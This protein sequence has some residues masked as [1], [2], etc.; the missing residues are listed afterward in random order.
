MTDAGPTGVQVPLVIDIAGS[1]APITESYSKKDS[2]I[3]PGG[4]GLG[5]DDD[6]TARVDYEIEQ[7]NK[8]Y[9]E[10]YRGTEL[11]QLRRDAM[12]EYD[13]A[14]GVSVALVQD[15][16]TGQWRE[17]FVF[18]TDEPNP[19]LT[20]QQKVASGEKLSEAELRNMSPAQIKEWNRIN[21][22]I[23]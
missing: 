4:W 6:L 9:A 21:K 23:Y 10:G 14:N 12:A 18:D 5:T 17:A 16:N 11:E 8:F 22:T 15:K 7:Y 2:Y 3:I 20:L 13:Q 1:G 19:V